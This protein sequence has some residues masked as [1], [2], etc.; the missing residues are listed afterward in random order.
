MAQLQQTG[1]IVDEIVSGT[2]MFPRQNPKA[3][4]HFG[5]AHLSQVENWESFSRPILA[6]PNYC[7]KERHNFWQ[8]F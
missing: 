7:L 6:S 8:A 4:M 5:N 1:Q 3:D 2:L